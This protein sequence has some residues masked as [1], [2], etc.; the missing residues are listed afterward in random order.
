MTDTT[1]SFTPRTSNLV[2]ESALRLLAQDI[3]SDDGVANAAVLEGA[4]RLAEL[5]TLL[6]ECAPYV[7]AWAESE[8]LTDGFN[9]K[10]RPL[11]AL[12]LRVKEVLEL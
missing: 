4:Q 1:K 6:E 9:R 7:L 12:A 3:Q 2:L 10:V 8:H 5:R 11:D